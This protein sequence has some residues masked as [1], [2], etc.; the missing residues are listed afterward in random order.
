MES[1][2]LIIH[3]VLALAIIGLVL[4][5]RSE[6]GGLGSAGGGLGA[7]ATAAGTATVLT[8]ATAICAGLF[9]VTSLLLGMMAGGH[10]KRNSVLDQLDEAA[11]AA[12]TAPAEIKTETK[13]EKAKKKIPSPP[14]DATPSAPVAD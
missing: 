7:F 6:G 11:P 12:A 4:I 10:S 9:F 5:Q 14:S 1:M 13:S 8:R 3:L 2:V